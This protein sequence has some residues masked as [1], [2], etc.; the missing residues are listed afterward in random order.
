MNEG[1]NATPT[2][3]ARVMIVD[4]WKVF[5]LP[6]L[7]KEIYRICRYKPQ[8]VFFFKSYVDVK[9]NIQEFTIDPV[10]QCNIQMNKSLIDLDFTT[11]C[12]S[13]NMIIII[14]VEV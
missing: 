5:F 2:A 6:I 4:N 7:K 14:I 12:L 8:F 1:E 11:F 13:P 3:I 9:Y 10:L